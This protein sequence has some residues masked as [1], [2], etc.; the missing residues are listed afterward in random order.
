M[1][2]AGLRVAVVLTGTLLSAATLSAK[3]SPVVLQEVKQTGAATAPYGA[4]TYDHQEALRTLA[5]LPDQDPDRYTKTLSE[6]ISRAV[7]A[8]EVP[9]AV[10][11]MTAFEKYPLAVERAA[12]YL[13]IAKAARRLRPQLAVQL[14]QESHRLDPFHRVAPESLFLLGTILEEELDRPAEAREAWTRLCTEYYP[15]HPYVLQ[16][17]RK[18]HI[19]RPDPNHMILLDASL[20]ESSIFDR[21]ALGACNFGQFDVIRLLARAGLT[22][23]SNDPGMGMQRGRSLLTAD[24][25]RL[26]G[27]IVLNGCY[28]GT[29]D[30]PIP[31]EAIRVLVDYV[32]A[33]GSLL[34][35]AGGR[36]LGKGET[37]QYYNPLLEPFGMHFEP[38]VSLPNTE[39]CAVRH[40]AM[41]NLNAFR[42]V[43]G[44]PVRI[45]DGTVLAQVDNHPVIGLVHYGKG[46]VIAAGVGQVF[47]GDMLSRQA[48]ENDKVQAD[49]QL[50]VSLVSY[51]LC[52]RED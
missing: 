15:F 23:H 9:S 29:A 46:R 40:P 14:L 41:R 24:I 52:P 43:H 50:L 5:A 17:A 37:A 48:A 8:D 33:G 44:V 16:G 25:V 3:N 22:V 26:Y 31:R 47:V 49:C 45:R 28:G 6:M 18:V 2:T 35:V 19:N 11:L 7:A 13:E 36:E 21:Y 20:R 34:V 42:H 30:P 27:L 38:Q 10:D 4:R 1:K 51:L 39:A 32:A 12:A